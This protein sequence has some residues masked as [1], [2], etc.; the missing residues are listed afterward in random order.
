MTVIHGGRRQVGEKGHWKSVRGN[1]WKVSASS[2]SF[3]RELFLCPCAVISGA[4]GAW[5]S[6]G[7]GMRNGKFESNHYLTSI[8]RHGSNLCSALR[9]IKTIKQY[10]VSIFL[11]A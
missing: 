3:S 4:L 6:R 7:L 2:T 9:G 10:T 5:V 11:L 8:Y 1:R